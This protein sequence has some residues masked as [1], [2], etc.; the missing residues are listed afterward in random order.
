L[1]QTVPGITNAA[2]NLV[3]HLE[4]NLREYN[5]RQ[6]G[7]IPYER[8]RAQEFQAKALD[9]AELLRRVESL[10]DV[11]PAVISALSP[12][13]L[14]AAYPEVVLER[15]LSVQGFLVHLYTTR[16]LAPGPDRLPPAG[17]VAQRRGETRR[18]WRRSRCSTRRR[19]KL[20]LSAAHAVACQD[21]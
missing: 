8:D 16:R 17:T 11:I 19:K 13:Q 6:L 15:E 12:E 14:T 4:G 7:N 3:L 20:T 1:W 10:A 21:T 18:T 5:G 2:G 9:K